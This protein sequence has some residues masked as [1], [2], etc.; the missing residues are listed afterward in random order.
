LKIE[1]KNVK[2]AAFASEETTC[3]QAALWI[4]GKKA[5][6]VSNE[7]RGGCNTFR[8]QD[9]ALEQQFHE[10]CRTQ[11]P[12]PDPHFENGL[13]MSSDLFVSLLLEDYEEAK[14]LKQWCKTK[15]VF[16]LI[17]DEP[18]SWRITALRFSPAVKARLEKLYPTKLEVIAN[19]V[20]GAP[21]ASAKT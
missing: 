19:E 13:P 21:N 6:T 12:L 2:I 16:R 14:K 8:F 15:T 20:H 4:D 7:G 11:P 18:G 1:L 9:R 3:F 5:A 17:G 10:Y